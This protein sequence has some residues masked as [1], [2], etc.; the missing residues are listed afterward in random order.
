[1]LEG[2]FTALDDDLSGEVLSDPL[3]IMRLWS[4]LGGELVPFLT[5]RTRHIRQF[6]L[7]LL[8]YRIQNGDIV[9]I[10]AEGAFGDPFILG[11]EQL[12]AYFEAAQGGTFE[13]F[14]GKRKALRT[15]REHKKNVSIGGT[16]DD[17]IT[18]T[19]P[20]AGA[21]AAMKSL[22]SAIG[23]YDDKKGIIDTDFSDRFLNAVK[24][25]W[26]DIIKQSIKKTDLYK[27]FKEKSCEVSI[28]LRG[29]G[30]EKQDIMGLFN[31]NFTKA[32]KILREKLIEK[33]QRENNN[34]L[35]EVLE[36]AMRLKGKKQHQSP[37]MVIS[38]LLASSSNK[39]FCR[40]LI[41]S[42]RLFCMVE[43]AFELVSHSKDLQVV[44]SVISSDRIEEIRQGAHSLCKRLQNDESLKDHYEFFKNF[45]SVS[46]IG[47]L[48]ECLVGMHE[49]E[50]ERQR[51]LTPWVHRRD[52]KVFVSD[53]ICWPQKDLEKYAREWF[54]TWRH[55]YYVNA[56]VGLTLSLEVG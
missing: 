34:T 14:T 5:Q 54:D 36:I 40:L 29:K 47:T 22:F 43:T 45:A 42:E 10:P 31:A 38:K 23:I 41:D 51:Q 35:K 37:E 17:L 12:V 49:N 32:Q 26:R 55:S 6:T 25:N 52:H 7:A 19:Q 44:R 9:E 3:G 16:P 21:C 13:G 53:L 15:I 39:E 27:L 30:T 4:Q 8:T 2:L 18:N 46:D 56:L 11:L 24:E 48:V 20:S 28:G 1:M 50:M 33:A